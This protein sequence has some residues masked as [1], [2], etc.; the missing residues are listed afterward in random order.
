M[1]SSQAQATNAILT[2]DSMPEPAPPTPHSEPP[3]STGNPP[4]CVNRQEI[5]LALSNAGFNYEGIQMM[6]AIGVGESSLR[7]NAVGDQHLRGKTWSSSFG[8]FQ[9]RALHKENGKGSCRDET[10]LKNGGW[11]FHARC[12]YEISGQGKNFRPWTVFLTGKYKRF[13]G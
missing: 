9:I 10:A 1:L 7:L 13:L 12:A 5:C 8:P 2:N 4:N 11:D 6:V 3:V